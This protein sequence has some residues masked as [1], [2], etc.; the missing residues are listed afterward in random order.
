MK[1]KL[2]ISEQFFSIQG[3]GKTMGMP[4]FFLRLGGCNLLC[5]GKWKCDTLKVWRNSRSVHVEDIVDLIGEIPAFEYSAPR[6][7]ITGGEPLLQEEGLS[8]F[9]FALN[10]RISRAS[11]IEVETNGT[12]VI[13]PDLASKVDLFNVSPKLSSS[14]IVYGER[15]N[16][17]AL[18]QI[19]EMDNTIFKFV[20]QSPDDW[21][22]IMQDFGFIDFNKVWLMPAAGSRKELIK[23]SKMVAEICIK[24]NLN[25]SSRLQMQIWDKKLGV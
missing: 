12:L 7:V 10:E 13:S 8:A 22:E 15:V 3:E 14:G 5:D 20:I 6:I 17:V 19:K 2:V 18:I 25:F 21:L 23:N 24:N 16:E 11:Y 9:I 4:A 1:D